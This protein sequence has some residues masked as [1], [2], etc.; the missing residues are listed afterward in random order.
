MVK[1]E[2]KYYGISITDFAKFLGVSRMNL[3]RLMDLYDKGKKLPKSNLQKAFE[4][5]FDERVSREEFKEKLD[6]VHDKVMEKK[7]ILDAMNQYSECFEAEKDTFY[8]LANIRNF[9]YKLIR[10]NIYELNIDGEK[11]CITYEK[12]QVLLEYFKIIK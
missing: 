11:Y 1:D 9:S 8:V 3:Y 7:E 2:L 4:Y 5:L 6:D 12:L 10:N